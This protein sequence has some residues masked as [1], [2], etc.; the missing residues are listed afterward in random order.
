ML[1][2]GFP[3]NLFVFLKILENDVS[4]FVPSFIFQSSFLFFCLFMRSQGFL[5]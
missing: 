4:P 5:D 3:G 1:L 2:H